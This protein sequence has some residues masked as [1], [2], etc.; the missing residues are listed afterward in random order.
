MNLCL[1]VSVR[2]LLGSLSA[3][4]IILLRYEMVMSQWLLSLTLGT[5]EVMIWLFPAEILRSIFLSRA[6]MDEWLFL[7]LYLL[8]ILCHEPILFTR[9]SVPTLLGHCYV[10]TILFFDSCHEGTL[11]YTHNSLCL[12]NTSSVQN[13]VFQ[14]CAV[15]ES[16]V[17]HVEFQSGSNRI[18]ECNEV[19]Y[20]M[21]NKLIF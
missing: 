19:W 10:Y 11:N 13:S 7:L 17:C 4:I 3:A 16:R 15:R 18:F 5:H 8:Y 6:V 21:K 20:L 2:T 12:M 1:T 14:S 9:N